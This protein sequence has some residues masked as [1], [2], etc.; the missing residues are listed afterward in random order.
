[1]SD[2]SPLSCPSALDRFAGHLDG[3]L[4]LSDGRA[5]EDHLD[6]CDSCLGRARDMAELHRD[7]ALRAARDDARDPLPAILARIR[8]DS[9]AHLRPRRARASAEDRLGPWIFVA[10]AVALGAC[11][12]LAFIGVDRTSAPRRIV[13]SE[14]A[15][16]VNLPPPPAP[17]LSPGVRTPAP[18]PVEPLRWIPPPV[19]A[20]E[21]APEN[22]PPA[23]K[24]PPPAPKPTTTL[25]SPVGIA[26]VVRTGKPLALGET[27]VAEVP[28]MVLYPDGTRLFLGADTAVTFGGRGKTL[29]LLRGE[30][31]A[32]VTPQPR[33][34]PM[35][36]ATAGAEVRVVGTVVSVSSRPDSTFVSVEKGRVQ[37]TR[38]ADRWSIP[39]REGQGATVEPGRLPVA[40]PLP[41]N[42]AA[43]PGFEAEGKSWGGLFNRALGRNYGGVSV[44]PD[45]FRSGRGALQLITQPTP[46]WDREV[47]QDFP[48]A[49]GDV[50]EA[51]GWLRT[52]GV[53]GKGVRLS[54]LWLGAG[55]F[56]EDLTV[57]VRSKGQ[58]L[59]EDVLGSL[60]GTSDWERFGLRVAAPP[61]ARQVRLLIHVDV[62]PGG[63]ATAWADDLLFRRF[64]KAR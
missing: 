53:S 14:P 56:S 25:E 54:L 43:D 30:V 6:S 11:L 58:V 17:V 42:L 36:L 44:T 26:R 38:K 34:E 50:V 32:D 29:T 9:A 63:P 45:V 1:M 35:I 31:V 2:R 40:R 64:Q 24:P 57:L 8:W 20:E 21:A 33:D 28:A 5:L 7:L 60:A 22:P 61:Q 16:V 55:N 59:R 62:D 15:P 12:L 37:V 52:A 41:E 51:S 4:G 46:G 48:V 27:L 19:R 47:F 18:E 13:R 10:A 23:P 49:P 3:E 39:V